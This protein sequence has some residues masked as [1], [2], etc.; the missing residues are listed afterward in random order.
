MLHASRTAGKGWPAS[1]KGFGSTQGGAM[2]AT[3]GGT[4]GGTLGATFR[5]SKRD[6]AKWGS[7][8]GADVSKAE[9]GWRGSHKPAQSTLQTEEAKRTM[10]KRPNHKP[11]ADM[12]E[13]LRSE[14]CGDVDSHIRKIAS[15]DA[16]PIK[17]RHRLVVA[18]AAGGKELQRQRWSEP[19]LHRH[20]LSDS[21]AA[22]EAAKEYRE[23]MNQM[24]R[25]LMVDV[26]LSHADL[27]DQ[28]AQRLVCLHLDK[29]HEWFT[30]EKGVVDR[31]EESVGDQPKPRQRQ[32]PAFMQLDKDTFGQHLPGSL[33]GTRQAGKELSYAALGLRR[34]FASSSSLSLAGSRALDR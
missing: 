11:G 15:Y 5:I 24:L 19:D 30:R 8:K 34:C 1:S 7:M 6:G 29:A 25:R 14:G 23:D 27:P 21:E 22:T 10:Q 17:P 18:P 31:I 2:G 32:E 12:M 28:N 9:S 13:V 4:L 33:L 26:D 16:S 20:R 3:M